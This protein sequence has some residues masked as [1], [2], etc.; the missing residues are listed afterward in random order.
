MLQSI[1]TA[2]SATIPVTAA[3][4]AQ[5]EAETARMLGKAAL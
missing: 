1:V 4:G 5:L 3:D 2:G